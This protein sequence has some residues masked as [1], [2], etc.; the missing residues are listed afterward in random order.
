[1]YF[2]R[3]ELSSKELVAVPLSRSFFYTNEAGKMR[4]S[5]RFWRWLVIALLHLVF[6]LSFYIDVQVLE[7][8]LNAS[9][10][11]GFH[12]IDLFTTMEVFMAEHHIPVNLIIGTA[13][14]P[15]TTLSRKF[16]SIMAA[17]RKATVQARRG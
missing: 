11:L 6:F 2:K 15:V 8:T 16:T 3:Y 10:F 17:S 13:T 14:R 4:P 5:F 1:M 7:G 12:M 9:R